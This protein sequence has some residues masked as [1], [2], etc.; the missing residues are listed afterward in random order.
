MRI[1]WIAFIGFAFILAASISSHSS[2]GQLAASSGTAPQSTYDLLI[3]NGRIMDG[4]GNPWFYG[5]VAVKNARIVAVGKLKEKTGAARVIDARGKVVSP[6]FIDIHTHTYDNVVREGVWT[7][8][9]E[10]RFFAPNFISQ[11]VT[12]VVSNQCGYGPTSL[13]TQH[14]ILSTKGT[15]PNVVLVIGHNSIRREVMKNDFRRLATPE[16]IER[17]RAL[18]RQAVVDGALGMSSGL[19]YVPSIWSTPDEIVAL[20][21]E[22]ATPSRGVYMVHERSS[23]LTPM[24]YVPSQDPPGP[25]TM[26]ENIR[27]LMPDA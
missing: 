18:D 12:T 20:V 8:D 4:S 23:G 2:A 24:W 15:G 25:P 19:E 13:V 9:N 10:K 22:L 6:G 5:D 27:E 17:M 1:R 16:E 21:K 7:G 3:I 26:I 14:T 11:G